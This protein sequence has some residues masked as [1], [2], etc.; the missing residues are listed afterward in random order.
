M[1]EQWAVM[2]DASDACPLVG[3]GGAGRLGLRPEASRLFDFHSS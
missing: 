3:G 1:P 2:A